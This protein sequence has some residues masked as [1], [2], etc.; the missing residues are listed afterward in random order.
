MDHTEAKKENGYDLVCCAISTI[1][2]SCLA[3]F[4]QNEINVHINNEEPCFKITLI[5]STTKNQ[6]LL[7]LAFMQIQA[8]KN[9]YPQYI[10]LT[11]VK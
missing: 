1:M 5:K 2:Y 10:K 11:K 8:I 7:K 6:K 4:D 3:W 9:Q